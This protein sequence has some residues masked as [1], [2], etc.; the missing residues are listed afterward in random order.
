MCLIRLKREY[1]KVFFHIFTKEKNSILRGE[2]GEI[3]KK[4]NFSIIFSA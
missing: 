4:I 2:G 1:K 3:L